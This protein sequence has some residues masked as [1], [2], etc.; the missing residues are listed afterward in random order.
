MLYW[1]RGL[2][3]WKTKNSPH[4]A[5]ET[6]HGGPRV[7]LRTSIKECGCQRS[8]QE[9]H[10]V[11]L[12][13]KR[14]NG[15]V[16]VARRCQSTMSMDIERALMLSDRLEVA[17]VFA[18]VIVIMYVS[19]QVNVLFVELSNVSAST[20]THARLF[21]L[22]QRSHVHGSRTWTPLFL[23]CCSWTMGHLSFLERLALMSLAF[24]VL[25]PHSFFGPSFIF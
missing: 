20:N 5:F 9:N 15:Y 24:F 12:A 25:Q 18:I 21:F 19:L 17:R 1:A 16:P 11:Y 7:M 14:K 10:L 6:L 4:F 22:L 8:T 2:S 23:C 13:L 3:V